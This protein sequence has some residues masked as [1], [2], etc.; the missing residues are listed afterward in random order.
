MKQR[1]QWHWSHGNKGNSW[2][3]EATEPHLH[4]YKQQDVIGGLQEVGVCKARLHKPRGSELGLGKLCFT[5]DP[6]GSHQT[7]KASLQKV[8]AK[9]GG[10]ACPLQDALIGQECGGG[11]LESE[12][13]SAPRNYLPFLGSIPTSFKFQMNEGALSVLEMWKM[14]AIPW[15]TGWKWAWIENFAAHLL[16][17]GQKSKTWNK[18]VPP[19]KLSSK[20]NPQG[21]LKWMKMSFWILL[22]FLM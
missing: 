16:K 4:F 22:F 19:A 17:F 8:F 14:S 3:K 12:H 15:C 9:T 11:Q 2:A 7:L 1:I 5:W 18:V 20:K 21:S 10:A 13:S 6:C